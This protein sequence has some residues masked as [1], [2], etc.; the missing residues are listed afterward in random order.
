M[1]AVAA[2]HDEVAERANCAIDRAREELIHTLAHRLS[3]HDV[4]APGEIEASLEDLAVQLEEYT[5]R[6]IA[7]TTS[8]L[9]TYESELGV[10]RS[11]LETILVEGLTANEAASAELSSTLATIRTDHFAEE[12]QVDGT[13]RGR[14]RVDAHADELARA[15][16]QAV[17]GSRDAMRRGTMSRRD[18]LREERVVS[19]DAWSDLRRMLSGL[20]DEAASNCWKL[21]G[22]HL[23]GRFPGQKGRKGSGDEVVMATR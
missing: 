21:D 9:E 22:P 18:G 4:P 19:E 5:R 13:W 6:F 8:A 3:D 15:L 1:S 23:D 7:R 20:K 17:N 14:T 12:L 11:T 10:E 2:I 16:L